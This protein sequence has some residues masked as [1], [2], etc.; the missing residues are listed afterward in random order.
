MKDLCLNLFFLP[1]MI[2]IP[3]C[4]QHQY[5]PY[6]ELDG[7]FLGIGSVFIGQLVTLIYFL[8]WN[9]VKKIQ[10]TPK[11]NKRYALV[12]HLLQPEGF[13]LLSI[14]LYVTWYYQLLPP[15]YYTYDGGIQW[16]SVFSQLLCQDF[17]QYVVHRIEH[18]YNDLYKF[19]HYR[20]H[21]HIKPI[22]FNAFDGSIGDTM[23]MIIVPLYVTSQIFHVNVWSYM[24]FG[25]I[26]ANWLT[27]IHSEYVHPWDPYFDAI[28]FGTAE[29]H[30][31]HHK[32]FKYN[33]GHLFMYW[34]YIFGTYKRVA[35]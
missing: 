15:S 16:S 13:L 28:G 9:H 10:D 33:Y 27:L 22:M 20:H 29:N 11:Y 23:C 6:S 26:Y 8:N 4:L 31:V 35:F 24:T 18:K 25:T 21:I 12:S 30:H 19:T 3:L 5:K 14:Y 7:L 32:T 1:C 34:D 17:L 2:C